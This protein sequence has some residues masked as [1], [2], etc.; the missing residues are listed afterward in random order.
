MSNIPGFMKHRLDES[1]E[2]TISSGPQS[3][4]S[5]SILALLIASLATIAASSPRGFGAIYGTDRRVDV[6][7]SDFIWKD[8]ARSTV[9][10]VEASVLGDADP[11]S[12]T[13]DSW[14]TNSPTLQ[15]AY[16]TCAGTVSDCETSIHDIVS[17]DPLAASRKF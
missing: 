9:F 13:Y 5:I 10:L 2:R 3:M 15:H 4:R 8:I 12:G 17:P 14:I 11:T 1:C 6:C 7:E 16:N